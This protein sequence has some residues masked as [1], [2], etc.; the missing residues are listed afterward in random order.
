VKFSRDILWALGLLLVIATCGLVLRWH[1]D[2]RSPTPMV[3]PSSTGKSVNAPIS[4]YGVTL[5]MTRAQVEKMFGAPI[6]DAPSTGSGLWV[7]YRP[8][9]S[10]ASKEVQDFDDIRVR[11]DTTNVCIRVSGDRLEKNGK[12]ILRGGDDQERVSKVFGTPSFVGVYEDIIA[13]RS[14]YALRYNDLNLTVEFEF[15]YKGY[16]P[17]GSFR[18]ETDSIFQP[19]NPPLQP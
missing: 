19:T 12:V 2:N 13:H 5:G 8:L 16:G 18:L 7:R 15:R 11:Y 9:P 17:I 4:I 3:A 10:K 14:R 1:A 6:D